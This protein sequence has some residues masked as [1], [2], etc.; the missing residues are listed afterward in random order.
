MIKENKFFKKFFESIKR[1]RMLNEKNW[2]FLVST[3][4]YDEYIKYQKKLERAGINYRISIEPN[5]MIYEYYQKKSENP[6]KYR[7]FYSFYVLKGTAFKSESLLGLN[8][9][10]S[11]E[12]FF[13]V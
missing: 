8:R 9:N 12:W 10:E 11:V 3:W 5:S 4:K 6:E 1:K 13:K 2:R 7:Y